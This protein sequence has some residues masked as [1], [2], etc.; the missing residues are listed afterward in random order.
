NGYATFT[1]CSISVASASYYTLNA[2]SSPVWTPITSGAFYIGGSA[3]HLA[4][5]TQ[6]GGGAAGAIWAQQPVVAVENASNAVVSDYTTVVYLSIATNPAGGT[7]S[8][9]G[10]TSKV[11]VNG[12]AYFSGCSI[13][14]ASASYYTLYATSSPAWT[15]A[16]SSAFYVTGASSTAV[17]L[18]ASSALGASATSGFSTPTKILGV[19]QSITIRV[20]S[21]P[22]LAGIRLGVWIA[23]K[24][25][26]G[27][28]AAYKPHTSVTMDS[29]GTAYYT[30]TFG[31]KVWLAF[32]LYYGGGT[33]APAWSYPSQFGRA[34]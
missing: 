2:T 15:A 8:C 3:N 16:T 21:S 20:T 1:G 26:N 34:M 33:Y 32:R 10:G 28:W 13:N 6:P 4:F 14:L 12:Y 23:I 11:A 30:Y 19:G 27:V 9:T 5:T 22:Q 31:S 17:T 24:G 7:L 18:A 29:T 25:S